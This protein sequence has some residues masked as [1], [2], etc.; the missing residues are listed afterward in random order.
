MADILAYQN[1]AELRRRGTFFPSST[2]SVARTGIGSPEGVVTAE[3]GTNYLD[4]TDPNQPIVYWKTAGN[5]NTG[6]I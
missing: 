5:G 4:I 1:Q 3:I 6:W 2:T